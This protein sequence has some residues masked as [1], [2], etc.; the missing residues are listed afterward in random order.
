[1]N[2][3]FHLQRA[4][5]DEPSVRP[6]RVLAVGAHVDDVEIGCGAT[7]LRLL[8]YHDAEVHVR[9]F[10]DHD[11]A[12]DHRLRAAEAKHAAARMGYTSF[13]QFHFADTGFPA[14]MPQLQSR[15]SA[16]REE[17]A[18]D[19]ILGPSDIDPHQDHV[20]LA[21]AVAREFRDG[22]SIWSYEIQQPGRSPEFAPDL[23]VDVAL[24]SRSRNHDFL[25]RV[26]AA[27]TGGAAI[28]LEDSLA[29][30]KIDVLQSTML[31]QVEKPLLQP[32][33]LASIMR[34]RGMH[35]G[36]SVRYAE[37][38]RTRTV[39]HAPPVERLIE[40]PRLVAVGRQRGDELALARSAVSRTL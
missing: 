9:V 7:I 40:R 28:L 5:S 3:P 22:E 17:L 27:Q 10:A 26:R 19:L 21:E 15:L 18:P 31:T 23:Y 2:G 32:D 20:A 29:H 6:L 35:A 11:P 13:G 38:F 16:L 33:V 34:L 12:P 4:S 1:M 14:Q 30:E 24:P 8:R 25:G 39:F 37:A 36:R